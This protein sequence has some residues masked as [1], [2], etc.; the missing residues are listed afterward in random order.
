MCRAWT[1]RS[2]RG[3]VTVWTAS[4]VAKATTRPTRKNRRL[5]TVSCGISDRSDCVSFTGTDLNMS[6]SFL[7]LLVSIV[8][9]FFSLRTQLIVSSFQC[10]TFLRSFTVINF[11]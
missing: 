9:M 10:V 7:F 6:T 5:T 1:A 11:W 4:T 2:S 8:G 3:I